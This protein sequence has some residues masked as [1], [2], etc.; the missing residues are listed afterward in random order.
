M[1][2]KPREDDNGSGT[3]VT[4]G[5]K[6]FFIA[7]AAEGS[8][9][10]VFTNGDGGAKLYQRTVRNALGRDFSAFLWV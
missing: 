1:A 7:D 8:G 4:P 6:N 3:G 10:L 9:V 5:F 2:W